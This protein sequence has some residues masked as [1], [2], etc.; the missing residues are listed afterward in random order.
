MLWRNFSKWNGLCVKELL[1]SSGCQEVAESLSPPGFRADFSWAAELVQY[2]LRLL[3][4]DQFAVLRISGVSQGT[5]EGPCTAHCLPAT[6]LCVVSIAQ[7][8]LFHDPG[9]HSWQLT[10]WHMAARWGGKHYCTKLVIALSWQEWRLVLR[11]SATVRQPFPRES[12]ISVISGW[13]CVSS[14]DQEIANST[15]DGVSG[16]W[17][18][19]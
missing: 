18:T 5:Q 8:A 11:T 1:L 3:S 4:L 10:D 15:R 12:V 13:H 16:R 6:Q 19:W 7:F 14:H 9:T 17:S 2:Y